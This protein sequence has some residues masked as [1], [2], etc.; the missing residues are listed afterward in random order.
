MKYSLGSVEGKSSVYCRMREGEGREFTPPKKGV[1][2]ISRVST[3]VFVCFFK[4]AKVLLTR[5]KYAGRTQL[6]K[7]KISPL[8]SD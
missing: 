1:Q 4:F 3:L 6:F 2:D 7:T 5:A 8:I